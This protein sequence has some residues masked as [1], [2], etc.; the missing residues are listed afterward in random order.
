MFVNTKKKRKKKKP[1]R[2]TLT[3]ERPQKKTVRLHTA[4]HKPHT[5]PHNHSSN[6]NIRTN[7]NSH[8]YS[9]FLD[10]TVPINS[11]LRILNH[12]LKH[13]TSN[14]IPSK[15]IMTSLATKQDITIGVIGGSGFYK[16]EGFTAEAE[17]NINTPFGPT[18]SPITVGTIAGSKVAFL[19][20]HGIGHIYNPSEVPYKANIYAMKTLGVKFLISASAVGSLREDIKP[21]EFVVLDQLIDKTFARPSTFFEKGIVGHVGFGFP[22][23][24]VIRNALKESCAEADVSF[25]PDGCYVNMEG[26]QFS[27]KAESL[28]HK[29]IFGAA[30]IGMTQMT[31][32]RL[33]REAEISFGVLAMATDVDSWSDAPHVTVEQV[34]ATAMANV[35]NAQKVVCLAIPKLANYTGKKP[36]AQQSLGGGGAV[37]TRRELIPAEALLRLWPIVGDYY[38]DRKDEVDALAKKRKAFQGLKYN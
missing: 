9:L 18:S 25:H 17:L 27:T 32:A 4:T 20:R 35:A 12:I 8:F 3:T 22:F 14:T 7:H 29:N 37:M 33:A 19:A 1:E 13:T 38:S 21:G 10:D 34:V 6:S 23:C 2:K 31:E 5:T 16:F 36:D 24:D 15:T 30:V 28:L 11:A 26:P